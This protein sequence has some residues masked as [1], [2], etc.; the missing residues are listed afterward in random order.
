[1]PHSSYSAFHGAAHMRR[2]RIETDG[3]AAVRAGEFHGAVR[4]QTILDELVHDLEHMLGIL[5]GHEPA[6]D[7]HRSLRRNDCLRARTLI[8]ARDA[9]ELDGRTRPELLDERE[10]LLARRNR[11]PDALEERL[12]GDAQILPL[13]ELRLAR[14]DDTIVEARDLDAAFVVVHGAQHVRQ[15][16][17]GVHRRRRRRGPN[18]DRAWD[19]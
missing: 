6:G 11:K 3:R 9:V 8:A 13:L 14:L 19:R 5:S 16:A 4:R 7:F 2:A 12:G 17:D 15:R 10:G 1:M 18:E